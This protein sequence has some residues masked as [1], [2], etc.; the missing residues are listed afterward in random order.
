M[1]Q[2]AISVLYMCSVTGGDA[3]ESIVYGLHLYVQGTYVP[4]TYTTRYQ[5]DI[6]RPAILPRAV[7]SAEKHF[8]LIHSTYKL[9]NPSSCMLPTAFF[10][11]RPIPFPSKASIL[12]SGKG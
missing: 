1:I 9:P 2:E 10:C 5:L 8:H 4:L 11:S 6:A 7:G 3:D 12:K